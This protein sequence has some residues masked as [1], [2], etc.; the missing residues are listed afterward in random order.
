MQQHLLG[1]SS[2]ETVPTFQK[3]F[4]LCWVGCSIEMEIPSLGRLANSGR[5]VGCF[6]PKQSAKF[7]FERAAI[8]T[9]QPTRAS[10]DH[11][12]LT[13]LPRPT[14][15]LLFR[16]EWLHVVN[17][18]ALPFNSTVHPA[19]FMP[20][21]LEGCRIASRQEQGRIY[22]T[23]FLA[24]LWLRH[25]DIRCLTPLTFNSNSVSGGGA[26]APSRAPPEQE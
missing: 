14:R 21:S 4:T 16:P 13:N 1:C 8:T 10:C 2:Q 5:V 22:P 7:L 11:S 6:L 24:K 9:H 3:M 20:D 26:G 15:N 18:P 19:S 17:T 25:C 12:N 23:Y